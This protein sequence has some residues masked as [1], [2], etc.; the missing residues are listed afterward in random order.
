M[1]APTLKTGKKEVLYTTTIQYAIADQNLYLLPLRSPDSNLEVSYKLSLN[2]YL[3]PNTNL[4]TDIKLNTSIN[5]NYSLYIKFNTEFNIE[6]DSKAE[7][8]LKDIIQLEKERLVK[9]NYT[10]Y[11]QK[12]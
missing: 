11:T 6:L 8:I 9:L 1:A 12:L 7:E 3:D 2:I 4:N 10:L 5:L